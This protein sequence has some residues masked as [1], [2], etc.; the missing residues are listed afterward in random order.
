MPAAP[1]ILHP[2]YLEG[3]PHGD[4]MLAALGRSVREFDRWHQEGWTP[5]PA[6]TGAEQ[7][8]FSAED[9]L[10]FRGITVALLSR[11]DTPDR[12]ERAIQGVREQIF[13]DDVEVLL[14]NGENDPRTLDAAGA[15]GAQ[16]EGVSVSGTFHASM[17]N[18]GMN[19]ASHK[20]VFTMPAHG[21]MATNITLA[22]ARRRFDYPPAPPY[23]C[24][25]PVG[26]V[27]G[28]PIP[29]E[30]AS[31][32]E[33]R[34]AHLLGTTERLDARGELRH[35]GMGFLDAAC[36]MVD[37]DIVRKLGG[38]PE[39]FGNG[40]A[41]GALGK[42]MM[43]G[44]QEN[45]A[46]VYEDGALAV[47]HTHGFGLLRAGLQVLSWRRRGEPRLYKERFASWHPHGGL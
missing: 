45:A 41:D 15:N 46:L 39:D 30:N 6:A 43:N 31:A 7:T 33:F 9:E 38:Y 16:I 44:M 22:A 24:T 10:C 1:E 2:E 20:H 27:Y 19:A 14:I 8:Q 21:L 47:H 42:K 5:G 32:I 25:R 11:H 28:V 13:V 3:R 12:V 37:R 18:A 26:G 35:G 4:A 23:G 40:G 34:G 36:S 17:L 29:D